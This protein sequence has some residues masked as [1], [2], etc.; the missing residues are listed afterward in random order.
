MKTKSKETIRKETLSKRD[1]QSPGEI[2]SKS[3]II[4][5]KLFSLDVFKSAKTVM[6]YLSFKSEVMTE[7]MIR[8]ALWGGKRIAV[9]VVEKKREEM[10]I[11]QIRDYES[12]LEIGDYGIPCPKEGCLSVFDEEELDVIIVPGIVFDRSGHRIGYGRGFYDRFLGR[13]QGKTPAVG[14]AF[15]LQ[16]RDSVASDPHDVMIDALVTEKEVMYFDKKGGHTWRT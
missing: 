11:S 4:R 10:I 15:D 16:L 5:Q 6:F 9:G 13:L 1:A 14:L 12:E 7:H 2:E 8:E 3:D